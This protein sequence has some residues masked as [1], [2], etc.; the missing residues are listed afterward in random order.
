MRSG[1][2]EGK[3]AGTEV[4]GYGCVERQDT[5]A[6]T[7]DG[8]LLYIYLPLVGDDLVGDRQVFFLDGLFTFCQLVPDQRKH[9]E[10]VLF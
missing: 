10:E 5:F 6:V 9:V 7:V 1:A 8:Q 4:C 3:T 2:R